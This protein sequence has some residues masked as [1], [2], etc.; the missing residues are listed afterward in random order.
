MPD[1]EDFKAVQYAFAGHLRDPEQNPPPAGIEERRLAVYRELFFN[2]VQDF[3]AGN[4][5]VLRKITSDARWEAMLRDYYARHRAHTP[6]FPKMAQ[7][8]LQYLQDERRPDPQ[9]PPFMLELAHYE[10]VELGLALDTHEL[11]DVSVDA[12]ADAQNGLAVLSP[13]A[14]PLAYRYPVHRIDSDYQPREAPAQPTCLVIYRDGDD[15]IHFFELNPVTARL[16]ELIREGHASVL[17]C[18]GQIAEETRHPEPRV[19]IDGGLRIL[20]E[21][22]ERGIIAGYRLTP[23]P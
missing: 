2:N 4:F 11:H 13:L 22:R 9:D 7:E 12:A 23:S 19:L 16:L 10:W 20:E 5:P 15:Q 18:L 1:T 8:F 14:W 17:Q 21:M 3:M 6:L